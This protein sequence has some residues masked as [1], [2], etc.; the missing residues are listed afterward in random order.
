MPSDSTLTL[1]IPDL[2]GLQP[3][4]ST[5]TQS[6]RQQLKL[7]NFSTLEKWLS[8]GLRQAGAEQD[9]VLFNEFSITCK[10]NK[11]YAAL[12]L[13]LEDTAELNSNR[14]QHWLRADPVCLQPDRDSA[15][16]AAHEELN[17][18][19]LEAEKLVSDINQHFADEPWQLYAAAPHRWYLCSDHT[20]KI[21]THEIT[22][23][24]GQDV[25]TFQPEG[26]DA[27]YWWKIT[28]EIQMLLHG[29]NV[30][31]ERESR[32]MPP[33]NS[34]WLW[35]AGSLGNLEQSSHGYNN[36]IS[37]NKVCQSIAKFTAT[38]CSELEDN[39]LARVDVKNTFLMTD[40]LSEHVR[41]QDV[42][43]Y[44]QTLEHINK[45]ILMPCEDLLFS[46]KLKAVRL[47]TDGNVSIT[48][49]RKNSGYW[50]KRIRAF[51]DFKYEQNN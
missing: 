2:F 49:N 40:S 37:N 20:V 19:M 11:P 6:D 16:I 39:V 22:K 51:S 47:L 23:V 41:N 12:S 21:N 9:D 10:D 33:V 27:R 48:I 31:F 30:N 1:F 29:T 25:G 35:G 50:W 34:L 24:L 4:L 17:L 28:N 38:D 44:L 32:G 18:S 8:R 13:L 15:I 14:N 26:D 7:F 43:L 36:V 42:Y 45:T 46:N 3:V 5:L